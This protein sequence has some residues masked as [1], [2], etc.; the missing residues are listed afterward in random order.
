M[1]E[2]GWFFLLGGVVGL[3]TM[4]FAPNATGLLWSLL[5]GALAL[6][7]VAVAARNMVTAIERAG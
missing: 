2:V 5:T 3:A 1:H 6:I 4:F 7:M